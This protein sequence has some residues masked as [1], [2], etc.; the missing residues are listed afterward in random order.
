MG[1]VLHKAAV[2]R[3]AEPQ[4]Q[5]AANESGQAAS[6]IAAN[7]LNRSANTAALVQMQQALDRRPKTQSQVALQRALS[8]TQAAGPNAKRKD[9]VTQK[10]LNATGL[11]DRLKAGIQHLSGFS[12]D[13]V[14]VH[15]NSSKPATVQAHAYAQGPDIHIAPGQE[16]HLPHEAWHVVQQ[17]QGRVKPT[18][19][20]KGLSINDDVHL[21][22]EADVA[23]AAAAGDSGAFLPSAPIGKQGISLQRSMHEV[24]ALSVLQFAKPKDGPP[25]VSIYEPRQDMKPYTMQ[26]R[27]KLT[28]AESTKTQ[29]KFE[30]LGTSGSLNVI[31]VSKTGQVPL[32]V[33]TI[34]LDHVNAWEGIEAELFQVAASLTNKEMN[35]QDWMKGYYAEE[36]GEFFPTMWGARMYYN[37]LSNLRPMTGSANASKGGVSGDRSDSKSEVHPQVQLHMLQL[38]DMLDETIGEM[39]DKTPLQ[40]GP[41][42]QSLIEQLNHFQSVWHE[43]NAAASSQ[44]VEMK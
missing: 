22:R 33:E 25:L 16:K 23:G 17:K 8:S 28:F 1:G 42:I 18:L 20:V 6:G 3:A 15:Y 32:S 38:K 40:L 12:M 11:P 24:R 41:I 31:G 43:D 35:W 30:Y 21:E 14:R 37:D 13:D 5:R 4:A 34:Q 27:K 7:S 39:A 29:I 2:R 10:K 36:N 26:G 19:Q 44:D 9:P